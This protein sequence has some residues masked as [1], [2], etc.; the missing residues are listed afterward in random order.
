[1]LGMLATASDPEGP[2]A[3]AAAAAALARPPER[4]LS[5]RAAEEICVLHAHMCTG[6]V[7]RGVLGGVC[8]VVSFV[9]RC[10]AGMS[11]VVS[12]A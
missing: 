4:D 6:M 3:D 7:W 11:R 2:R 9:V 5:A 12:V 1:M 8:G 10:G